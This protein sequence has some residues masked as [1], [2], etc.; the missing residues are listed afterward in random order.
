MF[1]LLN[2]KAPCV[3]FHSTH[4]THTAIATLIIR[5]IHLEGYKDMLVIV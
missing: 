4:L 5:L 1:N 2:G 3:L